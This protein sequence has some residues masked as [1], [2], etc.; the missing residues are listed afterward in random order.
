MAIRLDDFLA[1]LPPDEQETIKK[2]T[3][4]LI[5]EEAARR[6]ARERSGVKAAKHPRPKNH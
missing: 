3:A 4:E 1:K 6:Q 5:A 2:R